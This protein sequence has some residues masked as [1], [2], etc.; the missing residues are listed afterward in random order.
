M[1]MLQWIFHSFSL[2]CFII[3]KSTYFLSYLDA[4]DVS[5]VDFARWRSGF[6]LLKRNYH[7]LAIRGFIPWSR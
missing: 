6:S 1:E 3:W 5:A 2:C 7:M 4:L